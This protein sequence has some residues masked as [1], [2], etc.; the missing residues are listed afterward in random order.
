MKEK[1]TDRAKKI[2]KVPGGRGIINGYFSFNNTILNLSKENGEVLC[3]VSAVAEQ[4]AETTIKKAGDYGIQKVVLQVRNPGLGR[5]VVIKKISEAKTLEI[6]ELI[7]KTPLAFNGTRPRKKPCSMFEITI[8]NPKKVEK[9]SLAGV[10]AC[11]VYLPDMDKTSSIYADSLDEA[12]KN[13]NDFV[14]VY[15]QGKITNLERT[16]VRKDDIRKS[17]EEELD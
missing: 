11:E 17:L 4:V 10:Y 12:V 2:K 3:Q 6:E 14:D 9:G 8:S 16:L 13:A 5:D 1:K 15:L 7:D